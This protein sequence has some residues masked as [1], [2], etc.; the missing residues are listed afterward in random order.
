MAS[1]FIKEMGLHGIAA[2]MKRISDAMSHSSRALYKS[3]GL[4]IE[5]NWYLVFKL[6]DRH[7][8]LTIIEISQ[9][10]GFAHP[11]VVAM[12]NKMK[13]RGYLE[14]SIDVKDTRKKP[15]KL[16][17][18]AK[19]RLPE[20]IAVWEAGQAGVTQLLMQQSQ[21]LDELAHIEGQL[22]KGNFMERTLKVLEENEK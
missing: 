4:D 21:L 15:I 6:L 19:E 13:E 7:T 20:F 17:R 18:K 3:I 16:T 8:E 10:L 22:E 14:R 9:F 2:R 5:P 12:V 1:D 11:T